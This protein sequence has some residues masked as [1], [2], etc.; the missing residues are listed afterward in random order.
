MSKTAQSEGFMVDMS[1]KNRRTSGLVGNNS[2]NYAYTLK[3]V[4][5]NVLRYERNHEKNE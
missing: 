4:Q 1:E 2:V 3:P 5:I